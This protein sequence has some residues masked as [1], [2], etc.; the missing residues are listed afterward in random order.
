MDFTS[1]V[2]RSLVSSTI[3]SQK[4]GNLHLTFL[5]FQ[6][7]SN[8]RNLRTWHMEGESKNWAQIVKDGDFMPCLPV[9]PGDLRMRLSSTSSNYK[10][11]PSR[12]LVFPLLQSDYLH[13]PDANVLYV[14][15]LGGWFASFRGCLRKPNALQEERGRFCNWIRWVNWFRRSHNFQIKF[16]RLL[17]CL[18]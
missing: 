16:P 14:K 7:M 9:A 17:T 11:I 12:T 6:K 3:H 10:A 18:A 2:K 13:G 4:A 8:G 5:L 15:S 1:Y